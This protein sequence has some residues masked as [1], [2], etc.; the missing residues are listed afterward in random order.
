MISANLLSGDFILNLINNPDIKQHT[1]SQGQVKA[2]LSFKRVLVLRTDIVPRQNAYKIEE[3]RMNT[4]LYWFA[5]QHMLS[6]IFRIKKM[7]FRISE[8]TDYTGQ[9]L[10]FRLS[11]LK[12]LAT[13]V[14]RGLII[15]WL[16]MK[17][18]YILLGRGNIEALDADMFKDIVLGGMGIAGVIL[19]LYCSNV[20][21]I[22]SAKY[23][24]APKRLANTFKNDIVT[25]SC[26]KQIIGYIVIC[27]ILLFECIIGIKLC[28]V[29][30]FTLLFLTIH[31]VVTFSITGNRTYTLSDTFQMANPHYVR[32]G[33]S[34]KKISNQRF[35]SR[36]I[37]FQ[38]HFQKICGYNLSA[39]L[40]I[41]KYSRDIPKTQNIAMQEFMVNNLLL[42]GSY[43][44]VKPSIYFNSRWFR[45][46]ASYKQ[47][48]YA[49][50]SEIEI[51][52]K[53][54]TFLTTD[55]ERD[56]WWFEDEVLQ[57]NYLCL[58]KLL[59]DYDLEAIQSYL[60]QLTLIS[61][62]SIDAGSVSYWV[63]YLIKIQN[64]LLSSIGKIPSNT[65]KENE[66]I[67][68]SI[69]D[70]MCCAYMN[71]IVEIIRGLPNFDPEKEFQKAK[72]I[73]KYSK[74]RFANNKCLNNLDC[75]RMYRHIEAEYAIERKRITPN[76]FIEQTVAYQIYKSL[77]EVIDTIIRMLNEIFGLGKQ[78]YDNKHI[79]SAAVV[80]SHCV[81]MESKC[82]IFIS[83]FRNVFL[84]LE[85][86]HFESSIIWEKVS[87]DYLEKE[88]NSIETETPSYLSKCCGAFALDHWEKREK[89]PDFL[90]FCYNHLCEHLLRAIETDDIKKFEAIYIDFFSVVL[91]YQ[92]YVRTS[93]VKRKEEYM[94]NI[95]FH[96]LTSPFV[97]YG[98]ISG[99]AI[100]WGEFTGNTHW[101]ALIEATL[102]HFIDEAPEKHKKVIQSI[103]K[104]VEV[105]RHGIVGIGNRDVLQT[106]WE[107]R[108]AN[109][110]MQNE[111]F[112][113]EY[114]PFGA[115][116]LKTNSK[117]LSA[118]VGRLFDSH[119]QL[120][121][122]EDVYFVKCVNPYLENDQ[123]YKSQSG[124]EDELNESE[125]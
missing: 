1:F 104:S 103:T 122:S 44:K 72:A 37:N 6:F 50:D 79:Y 113:L 64:R 27:I 10:S 9:T 23:T 77:G 114:H 4:K 86:K 36:D 63:G 25:N 46:I 17:L 71:I 34:I 107:M 60:I 31:M 78:L 59:D 48:H 14:V 109:A 54:G 18:D 49:S 28:L 16:I 121:D 115:E 15:T 19:G 119:V 88:L 7:L 3:Y 39:L 82:E 84:A 13:Q 66:E 125:S 96:V 41:A 118:F 80:F 69:M 68:S 105:R 90:G 56:T 33:T 21:S 120:N 5:R 74:C 24:N 95:V 61:K 12:T 75:E 47:W 87:L 89:S 51:A 65:E 42:I 97:E 123:K 117:L 43:W 35:F 100:I 52:T 116:V 29:S 11:I 62:L 30:I 94:Q 106:G 112:Q 38:N 40:D 20:A 85:E 57:I 45:D 32:I 58:E 99:L 124:W 108:I 81:E 101:E 8:K 2:V 67:I 22:F 92:E 53:T 102:K 110:M 98:I 111:I 73:K 76:W 55:T 83:G 93:V 70:V 91:L 26:I